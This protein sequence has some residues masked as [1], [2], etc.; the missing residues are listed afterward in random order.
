MKNGQVCQ[1]V[2]QIGEYITNRNPIQ[3]TGK[4]DIWPSNSSLGNNNAPIS[5]A[6][7]HY[8]SSK[9]RINDDARVPVCQINDSRVLEDGDP[10]GDNISGRR[11]FLRREFRVM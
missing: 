7:E 9:L 11:E 3:L 4:F 6:Q 1:A 5:S 2:W 8:S 10:S